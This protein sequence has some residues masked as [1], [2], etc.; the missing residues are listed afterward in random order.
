MRVLFLSLIIVVIDQV[1][2]LFIKGFSIPFLDIRFSGLPYAEQYDI[3]GSFFKITFIENPGMAFGIEL[4]ATSKLF[5]SLFS[6]F[7]SIGIILYLYKVRNEGLKIRL[8]LA[9]IL[10]GAAGNLIDRVFYG[11]FYGYAPLFYGKVVD[12]FQIQ[13]MNVRLLGYSFENL[14]IFNVADISVTIGVFLLMFFGR[15]FSE[16]EENLLPAGEL[17]ED[18]SSG[19]S[20]VDDKS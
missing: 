15:R 17:K 3:F 5:L 16:R 13:L 2:K 10:G 6:I 12:F 18:Y 7:A 19:E 4:G 20:K 14:P 9:L 1:S 8:P 11:V